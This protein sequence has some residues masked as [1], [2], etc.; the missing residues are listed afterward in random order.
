MAWSRDEARLNTSSFTAYSYTEVDWEV[1]G[2]HCSYRHIGGITSPY[3]FN[4]QATATAQWWESGSWTDYGS[5]SGTFTGYGDLPLFDLT[6]T[7]QRQAADRVVSVGTYTSMMGASARSYIDYTVPHLAPAVTFDTITRNSD[8]SITL[9]WNAPA[10]EYSAM[11]LEVSIDG[12][13][14]SE[15]AVLWN[16]ATSYTWT[17]CSADHSYRFR[18]RTNYLASYSAYDTYA[19]AIVMTPTAPTAISTQAVSGT[20]VLVNLTNPSTVATKVVYALGDG[21]NWGAD[22]DAPD[23]TSFEVDMGSS[24]Y[25]RVKNV[26]ATGESAWLVSERIVTISVPDAP[27]MTSPDSVV[28]T[29]GTLRWEW[30]Y[31]NPDGS[32]QTVYQFL[33]YKNGTLQTPVTGTTDHF[34]EM[35][36][37]PA[38]TVLIGRVRVKGAGSSYSPYSQDRTVTVYSPPT[39]SLNVPSTVTGMPISISATYSDMAGFTCQAATVS[40]QKDGRTLYKEDATISGTAIT[41]SLD[42]TEFLPENGESYTVVMT[43]R[44]S[45]G[46]QTSANATF[47]VDYTEPPAGSLMM[48]NDAD[49]G[50]VSLMATFDNEDA[51]APA[52]SISVARVNADGSITPLLTDGASGSGVVDK[53][54]PLNTAYQYA[55]TTKA[56]SGAVM[57]VYVDTALETN[58]WFAYWGENVASAQWNPEQ[59]GIGI[60]RPSKTRVYYAGRKDP[61]SYDGAAVALTETPSWMFIEQDEVRPFVQ[62]IEDGGRGVYKSCDGWVYHADF[63]LTLNPSYT[64]LGYYGKAGLTI[65]RIAGEKL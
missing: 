46:L 47:L 39:L 49:T 17:G 43:A 58:R 23:L 27:V 36:M 55:V 51:D 18:I 19:T 40:L 6:D 29:A 3:G 28:S 59:G 13:S 64:A 8:T 24:Q 30:T 53:Y 38:G 42:V 44:S 14:W 11:C 52:V 9:S 37:P 15:F 1:H 41:A 48:K 33:Y 50:Y 62:L 7:F 57:T 45:S 20:R 32:A 54:A 25:I 61:V 35:A 22:T 56:A 63:D 65:T 21:T 31:S 12:G 34:Y 26:N 4:A 16:T 5:G 60:S 10:L 2:T